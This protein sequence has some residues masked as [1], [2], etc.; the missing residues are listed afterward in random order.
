MIS[1]RNGQAGTPSGITQ[2]KVFD[3]NEEEIKKQI[4]ELQDQLKAL[5]KDMAGLSKA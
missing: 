2:I 1:A 4:K 3:R 5:A